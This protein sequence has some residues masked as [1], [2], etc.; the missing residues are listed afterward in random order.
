MW[1]IQFLGDMHLNLTASSS[2]PGP[3]QSHFEWKP[4]ENRSFEKTWATVHVV[5]NDSIDVP[6]VQT[7]FI[8]N[9]YSAS[10]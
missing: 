4:F 1:C 3:S 10:P 5:I 2:V 6:S 9:G 8:E 7:A